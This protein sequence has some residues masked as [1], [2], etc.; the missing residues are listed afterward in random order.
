MRPIR[1]LRRQSNTIEGALEKVKT[2]KHG[3]VGAVFKMHEL[4]EG[5]LKNTQE[6]TAIKHPQTGKL[7]VSGT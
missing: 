2:E 5:S 3:M 1:R 6:P 4:I 7:V